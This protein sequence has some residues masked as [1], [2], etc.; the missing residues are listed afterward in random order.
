MINEHFQELGQVLDEKQIWWSNV[1]NMDEKGCQRGG[2]RR[3]QA[4]KYFG[5]HSQRPHYKL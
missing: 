1:Y 5:P 4:I 2:G 3:M